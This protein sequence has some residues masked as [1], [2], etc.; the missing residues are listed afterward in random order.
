VKIGAGQNL[1][2]AQFQ[3][4]NASQDSALKS[5]GGGAKAA[6]D[7]KEIKKLAKDF[8]SIFTG[9]M[10]K[11]MRAS[12][13]KSEMFSG[14]NAEEIY[15]GMLDQ[16]YSKAMASESNSDLARNIEQYLID[17]AGLREDV[18]KIQNIAKGRK[19]YG[20]E[21]LQDGAKKAKIDNKSENSNLK[22]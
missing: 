5:P 13:Q 12:I 14:G 2:M 1:D 17:A 22:L 10:L 7:I 20:A 8:E 16:E 18:A 11:S 21:G 19:A 15:S 9:I 6:N 4:I 3:A